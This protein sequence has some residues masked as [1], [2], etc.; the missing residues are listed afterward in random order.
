MEDK[1]NNNSESHILY[2]GPSWCLIN[3]GSV[4]EWVCENKQLVEK[5]LHKGSVYV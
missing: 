3:A 5:R 1:E 2:I 4:N